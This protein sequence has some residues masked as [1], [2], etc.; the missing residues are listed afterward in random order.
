MTDAALFIPLAEFAFRSFL[1]YGLAWVL[2]IRIRKT[3]PRTRTMFWTAAAVASLLL[4][5]AGLAGGEGKLG[6]LVT[7][8]WTKAIGDTPAAP[9]TV[10][11]IPHRNAEVA[12]PARPAIS[13][14]Q[15][16]AV[17]TKTRGPVRKAHRETAPRLLSADARSLAPRPAPAVSSAP[18]SLPP[19][20]AVQPAPAPVPAPVQ[21]MSAESV[22][23]LL[24]CLPLIWLAGVLFA[25]GRCVYAHIRLKCLIRKT[26]EA[27]EFP[28]GS[29]VG[30]VLRLAE[31]VGVKIRFGE[32]VQ[33]PL[34]VGWRRPLILLPTEALLWPPEELRSVI[35]HETAHIRNLDM[36]T[37]LAGKA[38]CILAWFNPLT[39]KSQQEMIA[40][41]EE[42]ADHSVLQG[43][44]RPSDYARQLVSLARGMR[45]ACF[46]GAA[47][48][49]IAP[50]TRFERRVRRLLQPTHS[51]KEQVM[52]RKSIVVI[53]AAVVLAFGLAWLSP[54][55]PL[56]AA[57]APAKALSTDTASL[58]P[59]TPGKPPAPPAPP[60]P[61]APPRDVDDNDGEGD[62][63]EIDEPDEPEE[64]EE[65]D[66]EEARHREAEAEHLEAQAKQWEAQARNWDANAER[67]AESVSRSLEHLKDLGPRIQEHVRQAC[68]HIPDQAALRA[69]IEEN[70]KHVRTKLNDPAFR[71][72]LRLQM[73][74]VR[75]EFRDVSKVREKI[76][77]EMEETLAKLEK[78][79]AAASASAKPGI[80]M[81]KKQV[82]EV[83]EGLLANPDF[84]L[85]EVQI[86]ALEKSVTESIE[87]ALSAASCWTAPPVPPAP[88]AL[89]KTVTPKAK[90][91]PPAP[92]VPPV[93]PARN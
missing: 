88:P 57:S 42:A 84:P 1:L 17:A 9:E 53:A 82:R 92:P 19:A 61:P 22:E 37:R 2:W 25:L 86:D 46:A 64:P 73:E 68:A 18:A 80:A 10:R 24:C 62:V 31:A 38:S 3:A 41:Q 89:P 50:R 51:H 6:L 28:A 12:P 49:G 81:A 90:P 14:V 58:H 5:A 13:P 66:S 78:K 26:I 55:S 72:K 74:K 69:Q 47:A 70:M 34:A 44:I 87:S 27:D 35:L 43:G 60:T 75:R 36:L 45:T 29:P 63:S 67:I 39:W 4:P 32:K 83:M 56:S 65:N 59:E 16:E 71:E 40:A 93:P 91:V 54:F 21:T 77:Q 48:L 52:K 23:F 33:T 79:E 8:S 76:R 15:P 85:S 11:A 7:P 30:I 20:P